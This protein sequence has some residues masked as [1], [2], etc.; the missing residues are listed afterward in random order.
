MSEQNPKD[1]DE[2][3]I[4]EPTGEALVATKQYMLNHLLRTLLGALNDPDLKF[5]TG[6]DG[7]VV[8]S[9]SCCRDH[10]A[11]V[12]NIQPYDISTFK[13]YTRFLRASESDPAIQALSNNKLVARDIVARAKAAAAHGESGAALRLEQEE[14]DALDAAGIGIEVVSVDELSDVEREQMKSQFGDSIPPTFKFA[15]VT[16][17]KPE[18]GDGQIG[19]GSANVSDAST[20]A[21]DRA[22]PP[23]STKH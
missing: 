23:G 18:D 9:I 14:L 17:V 13:G 20:E 2:V 12:I 22:L 16:G 15:R 21:L 1:F 5:G 4:D 10:P 7:E 8:L 11:H 6:P 19:G 3:E